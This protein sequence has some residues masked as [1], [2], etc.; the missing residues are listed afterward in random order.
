MQ[1]GTL[2][3][4]YPVPGC[5]GCLAWYRISQLVTSVCLGW[6]V[7]VDSDPEEPNCH[8][9]PAEYEVRGPYPV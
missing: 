3:W 6:G 4:P 1:G 9:Y 7:V 8:R 5:F 2:T